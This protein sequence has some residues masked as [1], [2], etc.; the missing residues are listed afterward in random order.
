MPE[1]ITAKSILSPLKEGPDPFFGISYNMNIYR[2]CQHQCIYCDTRSKVYKV[3]DL[4]HIRIKQNALELLEQKLKKIKIKGTI[5]TGSMNDPYMP[6]EKEHCYVSGVYAAVTFTIT[7]IND[8]LSRKIEP[9][10][11]VSS[12]RLIAMRALSDMGIYTGAIITPVL[13]FITDSTENIKGIVNAVAKAGGKY[14]L[15]WPSITQREGQREYFHRELDNLFPGL[16][17]KYENLFGNNY[18]CPSP[19]S[20]EL[21]KLFNDLCLLNKIKTRMKVYNPPPLT[22][23]LSL[24]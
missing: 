15:F 5:G 17:K 6:I 16:R 4:S 9:G 18:N 7:T 13:P 24:F 20:T 10:A 8:D 11:P 3:G 19:N 12:Q 2:G 21:Y 22:G 1:F 23:Q 14:I